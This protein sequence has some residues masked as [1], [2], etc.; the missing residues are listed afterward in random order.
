MAEDRRPP[1]PSLSSQASVSTAG[2][3]Y[4]DPFADRPRALQFSEPSIP[5]PYESQVSL[6][7]EFGGHGGTYDEDESEKIPLTGGGL[8]PPA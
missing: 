4:Q 5:T 7:H 8:Y 3:G 1:L 6:P 2:E